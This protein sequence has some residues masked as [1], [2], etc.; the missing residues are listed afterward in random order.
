M[1]RF[2]RRDDFLICCIQ[3]SVTDIFHNGSLEQ[4]GILQYHAKH[5][6]Q[7][8]SVEIPDI[9]SIQADS[10]AVYVIETHQQLDHCRLSGAGRSNNRNHL[11]RF[12]FTGE[13]LNNDF[14][15]C[16][17]KPYMLK[18]YGTGQMIH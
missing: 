3:P 10:D 7:L 5:F 14:I 13:I 6:T 1:C 16:I 11:P 9:V 8:S 2:C 12:Y 17:A 4:P 15:R 18:A